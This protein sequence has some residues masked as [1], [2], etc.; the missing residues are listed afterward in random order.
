MRFKSRSVSTQAREKGLLP[1]R[2]C[3]D[4]LA[5]HDVL[6]PQAQ[7][8]SEKSQKML[9]ESQFVADEKKGYERAKMKAPDDAA[10]H[11]DFLESAC[12]ARDDTWARFT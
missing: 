5:D 9:K 1:I 7:A 4:H 2:R 8:I 3:S 11:S 6:L 12:I 10:I